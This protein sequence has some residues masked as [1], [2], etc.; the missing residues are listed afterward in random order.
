MILGHDRLKAASGLTM[1]SASTKFQTAN[2]G[3]GFG[4]RNNLN[5]AKTVDDGDLGDSL[6]RDGASSPEF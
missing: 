3:A 4:S 1:F 5:Q 6:T 2:N